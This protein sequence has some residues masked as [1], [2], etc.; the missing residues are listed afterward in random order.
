MTH[1]AEGG[2]HTGTSDESHKERVDRELLEMLQGFRV[3]TTG[4]QVLFAF[5]LTV[6]FAS[7]FDRLTTAGRDLFYVALFAAMLATICFISPAAQHRILFRQGDK[8]R[9]LHRSNKYGILGAL[10]LAV[11]ITAA[12]TLIMEMMVSTLAATITAALTAGLAAW[13]WFVQP[14][15]ARKRETR[16]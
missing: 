5:L 16:H 14:M 12:A 4:V 10:S 9:L 3:A 11:A 6:P 2:R 13:A 8:E 15:L 1:T 7:G